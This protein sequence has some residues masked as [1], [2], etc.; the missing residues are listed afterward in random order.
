MKRFGLAAIFFLI[1][2][3]LRADQTKPAGTGDS[4]KG[5]LGLQMYSLR[6][7]SATNLIFALDKVREYGFPTIEGSAGRL[8][9]EEFLKLL[10]ARGIRIVGTFADY[11]RLRTNIDGVIASARQLGVKY[12]VCG[13]IPHEKGKFSN[14]N[15]LEAADLFNKAGEKLK[16]A[17]FTFAFHIHGYEFRADRY[18]IPFD[19]LVLN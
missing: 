3:P 8:A 11:A 1:L 13:W 6:H 2:A 4:F 18:S 16:D 14:Q 10:Q 12:V 9:P 19:T 15:A 7:H 17:G 5:P